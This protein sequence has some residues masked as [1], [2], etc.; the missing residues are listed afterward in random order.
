MYC[1]ETLVSIETIPGVVGSYVVLR[2]GDLQ[3]S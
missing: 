3:M 2:E 1:E